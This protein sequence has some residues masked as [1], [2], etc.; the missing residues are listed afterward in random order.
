MMI[1]RQ[2]K[3]FNV[4]ILPLCNA[5]IDTT[6]NPSNALI[7]RFKT[8]TIATKCDY[9]WQP[10]SKYPWENIF[11]E[12]NKRFLKKKAILPLRSLTVLYN[13]T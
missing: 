6:N 9:Q 5:Y 4:I 2:V 11:E 13:S 3:Y 1:K 7:L 10:K 8:K 12:M